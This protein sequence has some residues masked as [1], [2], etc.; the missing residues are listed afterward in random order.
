M[1]DLGGKT[2]HFKIPSIFFVCP[3][4]YV[5]R[6]AAYYL[7]ILAIHKLGI[8]LSQQAAGSH[9]GFGFRIRFFFLGGGV[10]VDFF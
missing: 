3:G 2:N 9:H 7:G 1:S 6:S 10:D 5:S 8:W 4:I